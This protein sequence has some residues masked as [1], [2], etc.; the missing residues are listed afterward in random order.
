VQDTHIGVEVIMDGQILGENLAR[1]GRDE[2]WL[3]Q[4]LASTGYRSAKDIFLGIYRPE[5]DNL[6][7]YL[8]H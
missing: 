7:L 1:M 3:A 4:Q 2:R 8:N 5:Q 6:I